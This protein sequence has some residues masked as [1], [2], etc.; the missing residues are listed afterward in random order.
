MISIRIRCQS[1]GYSWRS[2]PQREEQKMRIDRGCPECNE[3]EGIPMFLYKQV[4]EGVKIYPLSD[5]E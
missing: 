4:G 1:C 2:E 3:K 5:K